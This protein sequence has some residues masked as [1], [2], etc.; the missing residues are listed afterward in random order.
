M[1]RREKGNG[2][3]ENDNDPE[4]LARIARLMRDNDAK[5]KAGK[6]ITVDVKILKNRNGGRG[7]SDTMTFYPMFNTFDE[8]TGGFTPVD[9]DISGVFDKKR[10]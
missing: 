10:R 1:E 5:A 7:M 3:A 6:G 2:K 8:N 4:R 9:E